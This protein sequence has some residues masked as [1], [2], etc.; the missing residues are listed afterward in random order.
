MKPIRHVLCATDL[1]PTS[2]KA[3]E[4]A[5]TLAK[6]TNAR[7]TLLHV[8]PL[9]MVPPDQLLDAVTMDRLQ[10]RIRA[11]GLSELQKVSVR[12]SR[13][14]VTTS[15]LLRDGDPA[16][17]IVRSARAGKADLVVMGTHGRRGLPRLF[18]GSAAQRV[19]GLAPCAVVTV[20]GR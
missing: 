14:G 19:V 10:K 5:T 12:A 11:W 9:P 13:A 17:Q 1:S 4:T 8:S 20:R 3:V 16:E 7:L 18:L 6:L 2:R 15:L